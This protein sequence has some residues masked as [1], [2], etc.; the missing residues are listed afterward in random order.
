[1]DR[2]AALVRLHWRAS[3]SAADQGFATPEL[4]LR[5]GSLLTVV[6]SSGTDK[7]T[8]PDRFCGWLADEQSQWQIHLH[9]GGPH[10][11]LAGA[12]GARQLRQLLAMSPRMR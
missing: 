2:S 10:L 6:G 9:A 4:E 7:T 1:L 3:G 12:E 8:L 11:A 5:P